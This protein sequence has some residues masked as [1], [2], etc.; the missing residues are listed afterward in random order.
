VTGTARRGLL[1]QPPQRPRQVDPRGLRFSAWVTTAVLV[2]ALATRS[3]WIIGAQTVIFA[4]GAGLGLRYAPY[5]LL[6]RAVRRWLPPPAATEDESPPRFAQ[7]V[8]FAFALLG[9]IGFGTGIAL[10][11]VI[12]TAFALGAAFLNAA[13][14]LCLGC[15]SYLLAQRA[16]RPHHRV[17]D[18]EEIAA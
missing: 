11:G 6:F 14:G 12:A 5:G 16:I 1:P 2:A 7:A 15:E 17:T 8:G 4:I 3:G 9:T 18:R 10:L 13:F